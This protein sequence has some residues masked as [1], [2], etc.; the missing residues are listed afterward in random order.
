MEAAVREL[1]GEHLI[2]ASRPAEAEVHIAPALEFY[3]EVG[4]TFYI[5]RVEA[6]RARPSALRRAAG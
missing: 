2:A 4:A 3:R 1:A 6:L 5:D